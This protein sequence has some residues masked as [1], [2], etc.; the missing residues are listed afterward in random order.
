M[1]A[2]ILSMLFL[3]VPA[4]AA[5]PPSPTETVFKH[6]VYFDTGKA[7]LTS[8]AQIILDHA[9][10]AVKPDTDTVVAIG[11]AD[12]R[13]FKASSNSKLSQAR[14]EA[15][16]AYLVSKGVPAD[17]ITATNTG[18]AKATAAKN[19]GEAALAKDRRVDVTVN[20]AIPLLVEK[21]VEKIVEVPVEK[22]VYIE[23]PKECPPP[24]TGSPDLIMGLRA[25]FG[26][27]LRGPHFTEGLLGVRAHYRPAHLGAEVYTNFAYGVGA[28]LLVYPYQGDKL[29]LHLNA[30]VLGFGKFHISANDV[31]RP[32]DLTLG[33]GGEYEVYRK[34]F[35]RSDLVVSLTA[36]WRWAFPS[37][38]FVAQNGWPRF[39]GKTQI[40]GADGRYLDVKQVVGN[41]LTQSHFIFGLMVRN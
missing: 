8:E 12:V 34:S 22:P 6:S 39:D 1:K 35:S 40:M 18:D 36:D 14:A 41:S 4:L 17:S 37:P 30:G 13:P 28:Q 16:K 9:A 25:A 32:W 31:P 20:R 24:A 7:T 19:S 29:N 33:A 27:G 3:A 11:S 23:I 21:I 2:L 26:F 15:V 5:E 38:V 10:A